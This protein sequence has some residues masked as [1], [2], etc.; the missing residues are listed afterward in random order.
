MSNTSS[1][2]NQ[3]FFS[4]LPEARQ[5]IIALLILFLIPFFL[6]T[7]TTIGGKEFQRHDITQWRASAESVIE[8][9]EAY[10]KEPLWVNNMF[11]GMPSFVVSTKVQVPHLDRIAPLFREIY[12]AFQYWVLLSGTYFLLIIMGFRSLS[13]VFG[14]LMYGLTAYFPI[15]IVAGHTNKFSALAFIPWMIAGYWLLTRKEK[16]LPGLLLFTVALTLELRA[17][18]PQIT[19]YFFYLLGFLWVFDTWNSYKKQ[20]LKN[21]GLVTGFLA[22]G[23]ILG[24]LGHAEKLLPLQEYAGYSLRGGSALDSSTGLDSGYAFAWSQ[25][26]KETW[27]LLIP[28]YFGGASPEYWGP[29]SFTSGP[30][31]LGALSLPFILLALFR[32][33]SKIMY[34]FFAAGTLG[35]MFAWGENFRLLNEFAFNYIPYF[36]KFRTP[37]TWLTLTAFCYT[38]VT[39]YGLD[40]FVDFVKDKKANLNKLYLPIGL[41]GAVV[42]FLFVQINSTDFTKS[43]EVQNIANQIAQQNQVNPTNP[44]VQ[45]RAESYVNTELVPEREE[46][47]KSDLLRLAVILVIG[48]GLMYVVFAQKIPLSIGLFGFILI[49]GFDLLSA[50]KRYIPENAIVEGNVSAKDI[51]ESQRR[52]IDTFIQDNISGTKN[53]PYRVLPLLNNP[54]SSATSAYFYP[55][56]GGYTAAKL[57][58]IQDVLYNGGPLD[59]Q[60]QDFN[61]DLLN[62]LNVKYLTYREGL[63]LP[64]FEPVFQSQ[65]GVVYENQ[66]VLPKAFF[67]D[68]VVTTQEPR[69]A[70]NYLK[71]G[72]LDFNTTAVVE[73]SES[74]SSTTDTTSSV[75]VTNYTGPEISMEVSRE[76]PGFLVLSEIYYPAG[77]IAELN[78]KEIPIYKTN[79]LLRG[80]KIPAGEHKLEL[81]FEPQSWKIGV[82]LS[83]VSLFAQIL[84]A[85]LWG[86]SRFKNRG[87]GGS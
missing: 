61:P 27:T 32:Q 78:G 9:R 64:G 45:R 74:I 50:D 35:M 17:G 31:Y 72:Q 58:I 3:D 77:W 81:R 4:T 40:W 47:A 44:Q 22:L 57:S 7:A 30:H 38:V 8:Y 24:I 87:S 63:P 84:I 28:N 56:I 16:K 6:F 49:A 59:V 71:P 21:W 41:A 10:D 73:T 23:T 15:I 14:S 75:E 18:H 53:Y 67:V 86:F 37:E 65:S 62:L 33:L 48:T 20:N 34:V 29:K 52:D 69:E 36:D 11:G 68:S 43:G 46:K 26:I 83:W 13:S 85:G 82:L 5:H 55:S 19:Y 76:K 12:P 70:F 39:V 54:Y 51:L 79:Y 66:N 25:G 42:V 60:S 80:M 1:A 2:P